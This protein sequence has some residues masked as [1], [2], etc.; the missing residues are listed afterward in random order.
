MLHSYPARLLSLAF[1][2]ASVELGVGLS[3]TK[4]IAQTVYPFNGNYDTRIDIVPIDEELS[5]SIEL[6]TSSDPEAPYGLTQ[7]EGLIYAR[8]DPATGALNFDTNPATFG[9]PD[10][11]SGYIVFEGEG[12]DNKLRGTATATAT[13]DRENLTGVGS[14]TL[15]ITGG[16]GIFTGA[17]GTLD[18]TQVDRLN[19][20]PNVLSLE[21]DA[22]ITGSI[23]TVPEPGSVGTLAGVSAIGAGLLLHRQR[24]KLTKNT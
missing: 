15:T 8:T 13:L 19:P 23:E 5:Q 20:D 14:G 24:Q 12:T 16:E 21:G 6:A 3:T 2:L 7:Y 22:V 1:A 9:L 10:L 17:T 18:F 4:A 11:P